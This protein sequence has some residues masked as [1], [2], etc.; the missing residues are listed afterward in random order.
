MTVFTIEL[1]NI[2]EGGFLKAIS[3]V[4]SLEAAALLS[5]DMK[6]VSFESDSAALQFRRLTGGDEASGVVHHIRQKSAAVA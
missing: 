5:V 3:D 4:A 2:S 1:Q 6:H